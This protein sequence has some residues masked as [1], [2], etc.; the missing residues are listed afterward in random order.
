MV[1]VARNPTIDD[2]LHAQTRRDLQVVLAG[3]DHEFGG[4]V[5]RGGGEALLQLGCIARRIK[6]RAQRDE[7][8]DGLR[9]GAQILQVARRKDEREARLVAHEQAK[10]AAEDR[11]P[12]HGLRVADQREVVGA[13]DGIPHQ[14]DHVF[15]L[16]PRPDRQ[17]L[18]GFGAPDRGMLGDEGL[19]ALDGAVALAERA[20]V[21]ARQV[22]VVVDEEAR[23]GVRFQERGAGLRR[24]GPGEL[25]KLRK[26]G[27]RK[28]QGQCGDESERGAHSFLRELKD[29][30]G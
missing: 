10:A 15:A 28:G 6:R 25:T 23:A 17:E 14:W 24:A 20:P 29:P 22:S 16:A 2:E 26:C 3:E 19:S 8:L 12:V 30:A 13:G 4:D 1:R 9:E 21:H 7:C 11:H 5:G 18:G 27:G